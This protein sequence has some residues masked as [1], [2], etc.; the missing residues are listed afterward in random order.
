MLVMA[1]QL[2]AESVKI[3]SEIDKFKQEVTKYAAQAQNSTIL[4]S[5]IED[6][7]ADQSHTKCISEH[8]NYK[9]KLGALQRRRFKEFFE[10]QVVC[11]PLVHH[12][13]QWENPLPVNS[14]VQQT[15]AH[16][17]MECFRPH[18]QKLL[19]LARE[20]VSLMEQ[21]TKDLQRMANIKL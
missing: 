7:C 16:K 1:A 18:A 4:F 21:A 5:Y 10:I 19:E 15:K 9:L 3:N 20:E 8:D 6:E 14:E 11:S 17:F 2:R 13:H 12:L